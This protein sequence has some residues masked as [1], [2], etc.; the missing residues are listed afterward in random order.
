MALGFKEQGMMAWY[1]RL[2]VGLPR[3]AVAVHDL[4]MVWLCWTGLHWL[5][6]SFAANPPPMS[7]WSPSH[8][9]APK[10]AKLCCL[11]AVAAVGEEGCC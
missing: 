1:D 7:L 3:L 9:K 10:A 11:Q 8:P 6:Y 2:S 5:R 4:T